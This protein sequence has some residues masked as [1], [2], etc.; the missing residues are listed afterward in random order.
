MKVDSILL[1]QQ[2]RLVI[3]WLSSAY[4]YFFKATTKKKNAH[5]NRF[6]HNDGSS[7]VT[8]DNGRSPC[9]GA[10]S[11][12]CKT[13]AGLIVQTFPTYMTNAAKLMISKGAKVILSSPT[14]N[15]LWETG[16]F[17]YST[18]RFTTYD[19]AVA[20]STG[21]SFVD[22]GAYVAA[23]YKSLGA[24]A[25]NAF[26]PNDHTHTSAKGADVVQAAFVK[27]VLCGGLGLASYVKNTTAGVL[28][29][30]L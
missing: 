3:S 1:P 26:F 23:R 17:A 25:V 14:P 13:P 4:S 8:T 9:P 16:T 24:T 5:G 19:K 7:P 21:S 22:H 18:P 29:S 12:T 30:C 27:G 28:G 2:S 11:E 10:G 15:N 6:G 20:S